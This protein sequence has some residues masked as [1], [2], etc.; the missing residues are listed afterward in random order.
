MWPM[1][2]RQGRPREFDKDAALERALLLFWQHGYESTSV[3]EL[4]RAMG[5]NPPSMYAA[6]GG[7]RRLF[8]AAVERYQAGHGAFAGRALAKEPTAREAVARLLREAAVEYTDP[9]HPPGCLVITAATNCSE[10]S[11]EVQA[12]LRDHRKA[13]Q[14]AIEDR[15]ADGVAAGELPAGVNARRLARFYAA[16]VQGMSQQACDGASAAALREIAELAMMAWPQPERGRA[17]TRR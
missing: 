9:S 1:A 16:T 6:F 14:Q 13:T 15:I 12:E 17:A 7:K 8:T 3:A 11:A 5:V 2:P 10:Q 4:T